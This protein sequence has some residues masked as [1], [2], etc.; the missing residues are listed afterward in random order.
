MKGES[1]AFQS[2]FNFFWVEVFLK[3]GFKYLNKNNRPLFKDLFSDPTALF[4]RYVATLCI[5]KTLCRNQKIVA[6][7]RAIISA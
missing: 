7:K 5:F 4:F 3:A 2:F 6:L 1:T